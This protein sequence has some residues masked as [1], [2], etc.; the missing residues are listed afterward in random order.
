MR[1]RTKFEQHM[2]HAIWFCRRVVEDRDDRQ[3]RS[4]GY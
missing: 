4:T 3:A 1:R 2:G